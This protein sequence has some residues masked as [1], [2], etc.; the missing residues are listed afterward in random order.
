MLLGDMHQTII[1][2]QL[3]CYDVNAEICFGVNSE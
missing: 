2:M 1:L 3:T